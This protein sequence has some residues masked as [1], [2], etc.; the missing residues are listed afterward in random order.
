MDSPF[1]SLIIP[2]RNEALF[3]RQCISSIQENDYPAGRVEMVVVDGLSSDHTL[4]IVNELAQK[5]NR[6]TVLTNPKKVFPAAVNIGLDASKGQV[7]FILGAHAIYP[8]DYI[9][10]CVKMLYQLDAG[11]VG[12]VLNTIGMNSSWVG[13]MI[14]QTL[15]N[16]FGVGNSRFRTGV[17]E[18]METDTVFGGCYPRDIFNSVGLFN[19]NLESSSD[20]DFNTRLKKA[21]KK[22]Y[23]IP[24]LLVT[25]YTR[26]TFIKFIVNNYRNGFWAIYPMRFV[27]YIPVRLRHF[28]PLFFFSALT[29]L[30]LLQ[31]IW[32]WIKIPL[33]ALLLIYLSGAL[34]FS[35][36]SVRFNF[37]ALF[38]LPFFFFLLHIIYGLGSFVA[39]VKVIFYRMFK[40]TR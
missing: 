15:S 27:D 14:Q 32:P 13:R 3:I 1:V 7:I 19:E 40:R 34:F 10:V 28:I 20:I 5:D 6:I 25:Y 11:N 2:C 36:K 12:G 22:I 18:V 33:G 37:P 39:V 17:T 4:D 9:S 30:I 21:G 24:H 29:G 8:P 23:I 26:S 38:L 16:P 31:C 35:F